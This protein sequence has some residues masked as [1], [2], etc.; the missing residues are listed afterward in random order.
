MKKEHTI[1][2]GYIKPLKLKLK[3]TTENVKLNIH[4]KIKWLNLKTNKNTFEILNELPAIKIK[5]NSFYSQPKLNIKNNTK[6]DV[7]N[8]SE[9]L[10]K[11]SEMLNQLFEEKKEEIKRTA[12]RNFQNLKN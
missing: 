1:F 2:A 12:E 11:Q 4:S 9:V 6:L 10:K 7:I 8:T 5:G 3:T